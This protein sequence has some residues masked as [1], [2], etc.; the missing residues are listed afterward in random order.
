MSRRMSNIPVLSIAVLLFGVI[1]FSIMQRPPEAVGG[2][3]AGVAANTPIEKGADMSGKV[4]KSDQEWKSILTA[5]QYRVTREKGT[6]PAFTGEYNKHKADGVYKCV[7][8]GEELFDS[9]T[10]YDS[11][12]GWPSFWAPASENDIS[13]VADNS[14]GM[15]RIEITCSKCGAHLG[16][17]FD[18]GPQ[19]T[20]LRYCVNSASLKFD[21]RE[22]PQGGENE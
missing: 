18:D 15:T 16:H 10:K 1:V 13:E 11:G 20:G 7:C 19:P 17:V 3:M 5:D 9:K 22:E 2:D 21:D 6:E 12:S 4:V 14:Y 8:C